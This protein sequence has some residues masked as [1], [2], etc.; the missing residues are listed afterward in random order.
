MLLS[1]DSFTWVQ[2]FQHNKAKV[3]LR[4]WLCTQENLNTKNTKK[5]IYEYFEPFFLGKTNNNNIIMCSTS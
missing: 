1:K 2:F 5:D 3:P 4:Q